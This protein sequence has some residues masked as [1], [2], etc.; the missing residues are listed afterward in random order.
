ML[1][2]DVCRRTI[3]MLQRAHI[4]KVNCCLKVHNA[5]LKLASQIS[6]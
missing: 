6:G 2:K 4:L 3:E 1:Y 5:R